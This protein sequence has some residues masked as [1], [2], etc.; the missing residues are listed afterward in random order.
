M[1]DYDHILALINLVFSSYLRRRIMELNGDWPP[2]SEIY[3][4]LSRIFTEKFP[5]IT[6]R[7]EAALKLFAE[8]IYEN[9]EKYTEMNPEYDII[10]FIDYAEKYVRAELRQAHRW[11]GL[12]YD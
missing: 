1:T 6:V 12:H 4:T 2:T 8:R 9:L 5:Q 11:A 10:T 3:S 7:T